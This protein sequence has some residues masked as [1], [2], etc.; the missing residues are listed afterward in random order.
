VETT[1]TVW[2]ALTMGCARCHDHKYDP[3]SQKDF[4]RFFAFFNNLPEAGVAGGNPDPV[5]KVPTP[6]QQRRLDDLAVEI[7]AIEKQVDA[8]HPTVDA[9]QEAWEK[10][11]REGKGDRWETVLP[12]GLKSAGG[13]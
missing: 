5:V 7:Q 2:L 3:V 1:S 9:A 6:E 12:T 4:Y 8:A 13:A 10:S 11:L